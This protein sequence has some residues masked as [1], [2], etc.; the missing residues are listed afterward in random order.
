VINDGGVIYYLERWIKL[1]WKD[2]M[3]SV[4]MV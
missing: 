4:E 2:F 3:C 1:I